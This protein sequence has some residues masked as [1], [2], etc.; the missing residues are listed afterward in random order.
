[1]RT[2]ITLALTLA[3]AACTRTDAAAADRAAKEFMTNIPEASGFS[4]TRVDADGD[5]YCTCTIFRGVQ[6]PMS[7]QCGC[8][9]FCVWNCPEGCKVVE[10]VKFQGRNP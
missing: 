6:P 2:A 5:G 1:M 8:T 4:C 9:R 3:A 10:A 7:I